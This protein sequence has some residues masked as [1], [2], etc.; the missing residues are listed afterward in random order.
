MIEIDGKT[1]GN[2]LYKMLVSIRQIQFNSAPEDYTE[3]Y[4][5]GIIPSLLM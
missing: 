1:S 4:D 5:V 3:P 2:P